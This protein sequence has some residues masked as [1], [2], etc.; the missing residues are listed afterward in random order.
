MSRRLTVV[1]AREMA[2]PRRA[3]LDA[4]WR[5]KNI[6]RTEVKA[7]AVDV[8]PAGPRAGT[9]KVTGRFAGVPWRNE[10]AYELNE[11]GFHSRNA[12]VPPSEATIEGGFIV[13]PTADGCTVIH[14]E[15]YVLS[16]S[17]VALKP[18]VRWYLR[19]SM[20]RELRDLEALVASAGA[21]QGM[22]D[23]AVA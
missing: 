5:I 12:N 20:R 6:E 7:D 14:Y 19:W 17:V 16:P 23:A 13:T 10:F 4:I 8:R 3:V 18:L 21:H 9:Y 15:Q 11:A 22:F 1:S 2:L